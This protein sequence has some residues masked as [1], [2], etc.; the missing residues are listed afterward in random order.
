[1]EKPLTVREIMEGPERLPLVK[2]YEQFS[3]LDK[4]ETYFN[5]LDVSYLRNPESMRLAR[6]AHELLA[7]G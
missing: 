1:M 6:L 4:F 3:N 7:H 2:S 5:D